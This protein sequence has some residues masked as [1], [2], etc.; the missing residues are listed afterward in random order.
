MAVHHT[1]HVMKTLI[2][3]VCLRFGA[4]DMGLPFTV[5]ALFLGTEMN[6]L[7]IEIEEISYLYKKKKKTMKLI[8]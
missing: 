2:R 5:C 6:L 1:W 4:P 8:N 3:L 7:L